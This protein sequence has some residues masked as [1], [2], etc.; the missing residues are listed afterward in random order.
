MI[1]GSPCAFS[2]LA[3]ADITFSFGFYGLEDVIPSEP[4]NDSAFSLAREGQ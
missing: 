3:K 2:S 1:R 4:M